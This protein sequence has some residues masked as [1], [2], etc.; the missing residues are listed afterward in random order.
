MSFSQFCGLIL[1]SFNAA[2]AAHRIWEVEENDTISEL[3]T[4]NWLS[5][6]RLMTF[7]L[8]YSLDVEDHQWLIKMLS[9]VR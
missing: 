7:P 3:T 9:N 1:N 5:I 8:K 2:E 6:L 4:Q